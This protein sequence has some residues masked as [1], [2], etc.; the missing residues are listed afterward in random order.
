VPDGILPPSARILSSAGFI[1]GYIA[2]AIA[3]SCA[4]APTTAGPASFCA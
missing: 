4:E 2:M 1:C 3:M